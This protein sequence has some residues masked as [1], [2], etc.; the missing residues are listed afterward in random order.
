[1]YSS[2]EERL[3]LDKPILFDFDSQ[4]G[5]DALTFKDVEEVRNFNGWGIQYQPDKTEF[6]AKMMAPS[7]KERITLRFNLSVLEEFIKKFRKEFNTYISPNDLIH[8]IF[9]RII[10]LDPSLSPD[11]RFTLSYGCNMRNSCGLGPQVLGNIIDSRRYTLTVAK[12]KEKELV[13]L[14]IINRENL[15]GLNP[16]DYRKKLAWFTALTEF[17][18]NVGDYLPINCLDPKQPIL[19]NWTS[20]N[21]DEINFDNSTPVCLDSPV[22]PGVFNASVVSF[23]FIEGKKFLTMPIEIPMGITNQVKEF[24]AKTGLFFVESV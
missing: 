4:V 10:A 1:M 16:E 23:R 5:D 22:I 12:I 20:F 17:K 2:N 15:M 14:A 11:Q 13:D 18:E 24:A 21:Y 8:A 19:T 7:T 9:W 3:S 6:F